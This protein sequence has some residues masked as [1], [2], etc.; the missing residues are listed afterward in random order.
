MSLAANLFVWLIIA[1]PTL[2]RLERKSPGVLVTLFPVFAAGSATIQSLALATNAGYSDLSTPTVRVLQSTTII[3]VA[4]AGL[5]ILIG[6][7]CHFPQQL[8][9]GRDVMSLLVLFYLATV[10]SATFSTSSGIN[11]PSMLLAPAF[12]VAV[13]L[14]PR[15]PVRRVVLAIWAAAAFVVALSLVAWAVGWEHAV[16]DTLQ[17][18]VPMPGAPQRLQGVMGHPNALG[19]VAALGLVL[20]VWRRKQRLAVGIPFLVALVATDSLTAILAVPVALIA[21]WYFSAPYRSPRIGWILVACAT[22]VSVAAPFLPGANSDQFPIAESLMTLTGRTTAWTHAVDA[23]RRSPV[24]GN[25]PT[26]FG[27][28]FREISGLTWFGHAHNQFL[29]TLAEAGLV[30]LTLLIALVVVLFRKALVVADNTAGLSVA[31]VSIFFLRMLTETPLRGSSPLNLFAVL[32]VLTVLFSGLEQRRIR[33]VDGP[34]THEGSCS[35]NARVRPGSVSPHS[36]TS[37]VFGIS[38]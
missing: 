17:R 1:A 20:T 23:W 31:I 15:P 33:P 28:G 10:L 13:F 5:G 9:S 6:T 2:A 29:Q 30:G 36:A 34:R 7:K 37:P 19:P 16:V 27:E 21:L 12:V 35:M 32:S 26:V 11:V 22:I 24:V 8:R 14:L 4:V 38:R 3:L 25:G 18:R